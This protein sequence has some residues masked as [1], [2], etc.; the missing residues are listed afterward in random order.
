MARCANTGIS[1]IIDPV[2]RVKQRSPLFRE[3]LLSGEVELGGSPT[4][5]R[6][7]G[8]WLTGLSLGLVL[9]LLLLGWYRPLRRE[10]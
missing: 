6:A 3:A 8:D 2:G 9:V 10:K 5:Y 1:M 4:L 7:W